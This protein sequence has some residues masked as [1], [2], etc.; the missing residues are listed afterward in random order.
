MGLRDDLIADALKERPFLVCFYC[1]KR[2]DQERITLDHK[3]PKSRGGLT[4]RSNLVLSCKPCNNT[5][6]NLTTEEYLERM[7]NVDSVKRYRR[8]LDRM[9]QENRCPPL[10][11]IMGR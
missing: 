2:V 6:A 5:K 7:H 4:V 8:M 9:V 1:H 11:P 3:I 10:S